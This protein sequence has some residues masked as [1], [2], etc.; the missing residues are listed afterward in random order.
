RLMQTVPNVGTLCAFV[1]DSGDGPS[2]TDGPNA[3]AYA[4]PP[5]TDVSCDLRN[6]SL[7]QAATIIWEAIPIEATNG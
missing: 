5:T 1:K 6:L 2:A 7:E 4:P 3:E